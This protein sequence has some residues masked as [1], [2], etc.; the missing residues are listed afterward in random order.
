MSKTNPIVSRVLD[1]VRTSYGANRT[2]GSDLHA[3]YGQF[4][5]IQEKGST[6]AKSQEGKIVKG[7]KKELYDGL[8]LIA[9]ETG[10]NINPSKIWGDICGYGMEASGMERPMK[11]MA[12]EGR[13]PKVRNIEELLALY[14]FNLNLES[15]EMDDAN[16]H[17]GR[18]LAVL[19][20]DLSE[21]A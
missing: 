12:P 9:Q 13:A 17:I 3:Q 20:V 5:L 1:G 21:V 15:G 2:A 6:Y 8:K 10:R 7:L 18:A 14:K 16:I 11:E 4:W 19:G